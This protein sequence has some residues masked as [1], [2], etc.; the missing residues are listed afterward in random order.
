MSYN[1]VLESTIDGE[2]TGWRIATAEEAVTM[3]DNFFDFADWQSTVAMTY[4]GSMVGATKEVRDFAYTFGNYGQVDLNSAYGY[5]GY[6]NSASLA[7]AYTNDGSYTY[8]MT[9]AQNYTV[10]KSIDDYRFGTFLVSG[11]AIVGS[12]QNAVDVPAPLSLS[13]LF[14]FGLGVSRRQKTA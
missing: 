5:F 8:L 2:L 12:P 4:R 13:A 9:V 11:T 1:A 3:F 7:G 6:G 10:S 14:L